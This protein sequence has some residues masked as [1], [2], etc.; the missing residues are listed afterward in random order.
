MT[1]ELE[2]ELSQIKDEREAITSA[3]LGCTLSVLL[4]LSKRDADLRYKA[5]TIKTKLQNISEGKPL[6]GQSI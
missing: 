1:K 6:L 3:S 5:H 4:D 2:K